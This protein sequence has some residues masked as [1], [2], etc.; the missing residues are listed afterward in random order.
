MAKAE[1]DCG[2]V[3]EGGGM[4]GIF[5]AGV[6][7]AFMDYGIRFEYVIGTSAGAATGINYLSGQRGRSRYTD[8]D[9]HVVRPYIG[10]SQMVR[11]HGVIDLD[12][13]FG[14]I[15][16]KYYPFDFETYRRSG[17]RMVMVSTSAETGEAVYTEEYED[18]GRFVDACR[19]S[20]SL[21][22][23]CPMWHIDGHPMVDGGLADSVPFE[24]ALADGC[25]H[26][27]VVMTKDL[28][29]RKT[30]KKIWLPQHVYK[31]YPK[32]REALQMRG[33]NYNRQIEK[34]GEMEAKG[35]ATVIRPETLCGVGRTTKDI[36][37]LEKLYAEGL[38]EGRR[39]AE[40]IRN[41]KNL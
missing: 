28:T 32:L 4:R 24:K 17:S 33:V 7:D 15:P 13:V 37:P 9:M 38:R 6:L 1:Y 29:Y 36:E 34:L 35:V 8:L 19:A 22:L 31:E 26:V 10:L 3:L 20:C 5:T 27:V 40:K 39:Y 11:G 25:R 21:P 30:N 2:L 23:V 41:S 12:F 18:Y 16:N 14:D